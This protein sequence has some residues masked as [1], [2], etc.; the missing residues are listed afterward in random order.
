MNCT[1]CARPHRRVVSCWSGCPLWCPAPEQGDSGAAASLGQ[2]S[3]PGE[4]TAQAS[5]AETL[6]GARGWMEWE[7]PG[8]WGGCWNR[9][10]LQPELTSEWILP[11]GSEI[12]AEEL[13]AQATT[14]QRA[15][16]VA[17]VCSHAS[18]RSS[19]V[20]TDGSCGLNSGEVVTVGKRIKLSLRTCLEGILRDWPRSK[21]DGLKDI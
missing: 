16:G 15:T 12:K 3:L 19:C 6:E 8:M 9:G 11:R 4:A 17:K 13:R 14:R 21:I 20:L 5:V 2:G 7:H 10:F 18:L 1:V